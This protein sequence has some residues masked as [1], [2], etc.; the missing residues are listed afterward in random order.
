M[1]IVDHL[2]F[3]IFGIQAWQKPNTFAKIKSEK[4]VSQHEPHSVHSNPANPLPNRYQP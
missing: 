2:A 4:Q 1:A 3:L